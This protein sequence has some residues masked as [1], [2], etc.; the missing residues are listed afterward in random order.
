MQNTSTEYDLDSVDG[1]NTMT[2]GLS[3]QN[4]VWAIVSLFR[5]SRDSFDSASVRGRFV[6]R[7]LVVFHLE[8]FV[9]FSLLSHSIV[10]GS[11]KKKDVVGREDTLD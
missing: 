1:R 8:F 3:R 2:S 11:A 4:L 10:T 9:R 5:S 7:S 6:S